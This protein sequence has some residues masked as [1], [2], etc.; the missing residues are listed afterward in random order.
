MDCREGIVKSIDSF[1]AT[2]ELIRASAC[3][4]C[5]ARGACLSTDRHTHVLIVTDYP[6]DLK[7]GQRVEIHTPKGQGLRATLWAFVL[8]LLLIIIAVILLQHRHVTDR[9]LA[10]AC[11]GILLI[12]YGVLYMLKDI[13]SRHFRFRITHKS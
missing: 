2:V 3:S 5:H 1:G 4:S 11:L 7:V 6:T 12:Y 13:F 10:L 8:P 9:M